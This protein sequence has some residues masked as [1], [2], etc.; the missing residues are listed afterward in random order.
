M[1]KANKDSRSTN[2]TNTLANPI[3]ELT[4]YIEEKFTS[5]EKRIVSVD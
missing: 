3:T 4:I 2:S 1:L 5:L